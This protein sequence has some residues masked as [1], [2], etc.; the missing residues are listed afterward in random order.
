[1]RIFYSD[2]GDDQA[3]FARIEALIAHLKAGG[4]TVC[5]TTRGPVDTVGQALPLP[6]IIR[7]SLVDGGY[8]LH[9]DAPA[10]DALTLYSAGAF[11]YDHPKKSAADCYASV[12]VYRQYIEHELDRFAPDLVILWH[13]FNAYHYIITDWCRRRGTPVIYGEH[14]VLPGSWC[15][16]YHG[17][18]AESWI[19]QA[20]K[21]FA[22]LPIDEA[23]LEH[24]R[25]WLDHAV[26]ARL[27]RKTGMTPLQDEALRARLDSDPR[28]KILYTGVNDYKTG[29]LPFSRSRTLQHTGDFI[30]TEAGLRALLPLAQKH[31]WHILYKPHPSIRHEFR[32]AEAAKGHLTMIDKSVDLIDMLSR[33][34]A[35]ATIL[36][37]SA[38]MSLIHGRPTILM[39]RMQLSGSGLV[40]EAPYRRALEAAVRTALKRDDAAARRG[41]LIAHIAR[42]MRYYVIS[43]DYGDRGM[44][45]Y[46]LSH[47]AESLLK[48]ARSSDRKTA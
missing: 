4:A 41:K 11:R 23:D 35:M 25:A 12:H 43:P 47:F 19:A 17:Q 15:F 14:G 30:S 7:R 40:H 2:Y 13:Q 22:E 9:P 33:S 38:Y 31:G 46:D 1:M 26:A 5:R 37:Q 10:D 42:L 6:N 27:N 24:A 45:R 3:R 20:P 18:M 48:S 21:R 44:F 28:P 39:G 32:E 29:L 8:A 36:S 16:E 34:D